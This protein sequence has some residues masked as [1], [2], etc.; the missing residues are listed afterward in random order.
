MTIPMWEDNTTALAMAYKR[1]GTTVQVPLRRRILA[2]CVRFNVRVQA[3]YINTKDN[4]L[5]FHLSRGDR[6]AFR[7]AYKLWLAMELWTKIVRIGCGSPQ[8]SR[9]LTKKWV[10]SMSRHAA[11]TAARICTFANLWSART[12][13]NGIGR[14]ETSFQTLRS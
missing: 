1:K 8:T 6:R 14:G 11:T 3:R 12:A 5:A 2:I 4:I 13:A 9:R 7:K 10:L